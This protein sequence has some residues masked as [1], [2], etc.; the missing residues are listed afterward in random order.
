MHPSC[1]DS[2]FL[3]FICSYS[4]IP[5]MIIELT[6]YVTIEEMLVAIQDISFKCNSLKTGSALAFAAHAMSRLDTVREDAA[7][8]SDLL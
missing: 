2:V 8:V 1:N 7:K 5:R 6:D 4:P 3:L